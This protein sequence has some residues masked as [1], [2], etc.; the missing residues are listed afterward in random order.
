MRAMFRQQVNL[1]YRS[2]DMPIIIAHRSDSDK[3]L[4][5]LSDVEGFCRVCDLDRGI[6]TPRL[7]VEDAIVSAGWVEIDNDPELLAKAMACRE[8]KQT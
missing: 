2:F 6:A 8:P 5:V 4:L 1:G 3:I 7:R